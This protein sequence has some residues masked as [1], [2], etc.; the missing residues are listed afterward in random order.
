MSGAASTLPP[1]PMHGR[2]VLP[3]GGML[4]QRG[5]AALDATDA[6]PAA[7]SAASQRQP[8]AAA[9][10][11]TDCTTTKAGAS[12]GAIPAKVAVRLRATVTAGLAKLV[13]A[14]DQ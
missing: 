5:A 14:A 6:L 9:S 10:A 1:R 13:E 4:G 12:P 3:R 7:A 8:A 2:P 11:A